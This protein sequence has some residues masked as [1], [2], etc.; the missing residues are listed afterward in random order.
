M[1]S[2]AIVCGQE[3]ENVLKRIEVTR[4]SRKKKGKGWKG[5]L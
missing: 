1:G 5:T 3:E 2:I 4:S